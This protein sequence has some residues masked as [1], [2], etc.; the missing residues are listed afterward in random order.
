MTNNTLDPDDWDEYRKQAHKM[1]DASI[2]K[3]QG[4]K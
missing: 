1:L 3:M 4:G 2:D